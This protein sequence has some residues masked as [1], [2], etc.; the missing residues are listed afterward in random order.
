[1]RQTG[2]DNEC[3]SVTAIGLKLVL[4]VSCTHQ[5][6]SKFFFFINMGSDGQRYMPRHTNDSSR[7]A[8]RGGNRSCNHNHVFPLL[9]LGR[10]FH[11]CLSG[12]FCAANAVQATGH[13]G[14][15]TQSITLITTW[16][17]RQ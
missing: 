10:V 5:S 1:M 4:T 8:Y 15:I 6:V 12:G 17:N 16:D 14:P 7:L 9:M 11:V 3:E 2:L 13:T